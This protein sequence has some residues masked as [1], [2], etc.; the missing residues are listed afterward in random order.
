[1]YSLHK[2]SYSFRNNRSSCYKCIKNHYSEKVYRISIKILATESLIIQVADYD[3][4]KL[5]KRDSTK[6]IIV[7]ILSWEK[8]NFEYFLTFRSFLRR[9]CA[10]HRVAYIR[11][12]W[13]NKSVTSNCMPNGFHFAFWSRSAGRSAQTYERWPFLRKMTFLMIRVPHVVASPMNFSLLCD[14]GQQVGVFKLMKND[15]FLAV[16]AI[17][18]NF[19]GTLRSSFY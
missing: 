13:N 19:L 18:P 8:F 15:H 6:R 1:M 7:G 17:F 2:L 4:T 16:L 5:I 12:P 3:P 14:Q 9:F 10:G 11:V